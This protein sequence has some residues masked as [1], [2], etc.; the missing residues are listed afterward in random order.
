MRLDLLRDVY[1]YDL[2]NQVWELTGRMLPREGGRSNDTDGDAGA[3]DRTQDWRFHG[4]SI[5]KQIVY[6]TIF[7]TFWEHTAKQEGGKSST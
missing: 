1:D 3:S 5:Q 7:A 4:G 2:G 6:K